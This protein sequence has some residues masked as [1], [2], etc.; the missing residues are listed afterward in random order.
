VSMTVRLENVGKGEAR[1]VK[2]RLEGLQ[3]SG[4]K[5]A[6]LGRLD[7]DDDAPAVFTFTPGKTGEQEV[8]LLVE[9]EDDFGEHQLSENLTFSVGSQ[10]GS[11]IPVVVGV[12]LILAAVIFY[13]KKK[14]KL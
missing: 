4:S 3:G 8:T 6:F 9:Y 2:A 13:M 12:V 10:E 7:K 5:D 1:S 11:M 14:G